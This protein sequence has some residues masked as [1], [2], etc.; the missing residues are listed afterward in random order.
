MNSDAVTVRDVSTLPYASLDETLE[1]TGITRGHNFEINIQL[2]QALSQ[3]TLVTYSVENVDD[4]APAVMNPTDTL[5]ILAGDT[6][7]SKLIEVDQNHTA[8][9]SADAAYRVSISTID[10]SLAIHTQ[11]GEI[12]IPVY[13]N[14]T[15]TAARPLVSIAAVSSGDI[16]AGDP[17]SYTVTASPAPTEDIIVMISL[18]SS[19]GNFVEESQLDD[20]RI[21]LTNS[22]PTMDFDVV[23]LAGDA[24]DTSTTITARVIQGSGFVLPIVE[25]DVSSRTVSADAQGKSVEASVVVEKT[26]AVS[27]A[28]VSATGIEGQSINFT[29]TPSATPSAVIPINIRVSE[30]GNFFS[31]QI[32]ATNS[33]DL[34]TENETNFV[35]RSKPVNTHLDSESVLTVEILDG[36]GYQVDPDPDDRT[37][38]VTIRGNI[39]IDTI[40]PVA[41]TITKGD[42]AEFR[43][44]STLSTDA[45]REY[46]I[47]LDVN[48]T[49]LVAD[50]SQRTVTIP[51]NERVSNTLSIATTADTG[52]DL[53]PIGTITAS[54]RGLLSVEATVNV[55]DDDLTGVSIASL[56]DV[57]V[58]GEPRCICDYGS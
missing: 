51:A 4:N 14:D 11:A 25:T 2:D 40:T 30:T 19:D 48:L 58:E 1:T 26:L 42:N 5:T 34:T 52:T 22:N 37:V 12:T 35:L 9:L 36:P 39:A 55:L 17:V 49:G 21:D 53:D 44:S 10:H 33:V 57:I 50:S 7:I 15:P 46:M 28:A 3:A 24:S 6:T 8:S 56:T 16:I 27:L 18:S 43:V 32:L 54:V 38:T 47:D 41:G 31:P 13:E 20:R 23:T 29:L 45:D